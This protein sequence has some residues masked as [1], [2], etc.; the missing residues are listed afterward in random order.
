MSLDP[1]T[2]MMAASTLFN[3][4][5]S[6]Q[7]KDAEKSS[8]FSEGQQGGIND[9][10]QMINGLKGG[11]NNGD[12]TQNQGYQQ[13]QNWLNDLFNDENFF[14]KFEDPMMRQY[15][16]QTIPDLANRF[17]S[18]GS[19]GSLG[20]TAFRN[21]ANREAGNLHS[22]I[23]ALR[24]GM[25]QNGVN[26]GLQYAQ[27][28]ISNM[29]N[30]YQQALGQPVNNQYQPPSTGGWGSMSAP[31]MQGAVNYWG[32]QGGNQNS[33]QSP[34]T[35]SGDGSGAGWD[36]MFRNNPDMLSGSYT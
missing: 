5:G 33:G 12:I 36:N 6:M 23:A 16:E 3:I 10:I 31:L 17:S 8:S 2:M 22:N 18:M 1:G 27:Q 25:Q 11:T 7:G 13:G 28:P 24:G 20:S 29:M 19:G 4:I 15:N 34:S 32:G 21:Q 35:Q 26:Q 30:M 9:I 14:K